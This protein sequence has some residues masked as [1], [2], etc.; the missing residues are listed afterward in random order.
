MCLYS[1]AKVPVE[2]ERFLALFAELL[3]VY[4]ITHIF[5]KENWV[6]TLQETY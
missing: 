2:I 3:H 1:F 6:K 4:T 5:L